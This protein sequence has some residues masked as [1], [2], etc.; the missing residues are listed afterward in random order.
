MK[1][2]NKI[3]L[4][5]ALLVTAILLVLNTSVYYLTVAERKKIFQKRLKSRASNSAQIFS[6]FGDSSINMLRKI[7]D[8]SLVL[9]P[10][11]S[12]AIL[13]TLGNSLYQYQAKNAKPLLR[14]T[15]LMKA[16][17][18]SGEELFKDGRREGVALNY[19]DR[20]NNFIILVAAFDEDGALSLLE[21]RRVLFLSL[22]I[23]VLATLIIGFIFSSQLV[24]PIKTIINDV[25]NIS[26]QNLSKRLQA[27]NGQDELN[28]LA[29]TFNDLLNRLQDSFTTQRRFISNASHELSTPLTS[30]ASQLQVTLQKE[31]D[32]REYQ[33]VLHSIQEDVD[34]MRQLTKN[35]LEIAKAGS[36]GSIELNDLRADELL[37]KVI[38][39]VKRRNNT[40]TVDMEFLNLPI[41]E[42]QCMLFGNYDLLYSA[43]KNIIENGC[44]YSTDKK[45]YVRISFAEKDIFIEVVNHGDIITEQEIEQ[46]FQPFFR[47]SN[48][49]DNKGFGLGL[50]LAKR[51]IALHKGEISVVSDDGQ[52]NFMIVLPSLVG[53]D[54]QF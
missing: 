42:R 2:R 28:Q 12:V 37:L 27:G 35:L 32:S 54:I 41:D 9:L 25:N 51:I 1:I 44:K 30:I 39:D 47:G 3:T 7:D 49:E 29:K 16:V 33:Q 52:T 34:Q 21:L 18:R 17:R 31:R 40:Y 48:A 38:S 13:D 6:Y 24:R 5:F 26:S 36:Q 20:N 50:P 45:S 8:S 19:I 4:L 46:I 43:F 53:Q 10:E 11:K 14:D 23:A 15:S 22:L